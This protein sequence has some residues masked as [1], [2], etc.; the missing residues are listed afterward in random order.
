MKAKIKINYSEAKNGDVFQVVEIFEKFVTLDINGRK[1]DFGKS[2]IELV[3]PTG[4]EKINLLKAHKIISISSCTPEWT[5][6]NQWSSVF[7]EQ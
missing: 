2:E 5:D 7:Y 3:A 6:T 4:F 1:V